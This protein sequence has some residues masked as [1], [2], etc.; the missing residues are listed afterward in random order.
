MQK[1][2]STLKKELAIDIKTEA[3]A[4][5]GDVFDWILYN[6]D[7]DQVRTFIEN[8]RVFARMLP[9]QKKMLVEKLQEYGYCV[10]F[11]GDGAN[12]CGALKSSD[13]NLIF[14]F[15]FFFFILFYF[16]LFYF[17]LFY[18]IIIIFR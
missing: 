10:S 5:T 6:Y 3:Y 11:C 12:D 2:Q 1:S 8:C 18:F 16:I 4:M 15:L 13:V 9:D 17:I 7:D 14:F